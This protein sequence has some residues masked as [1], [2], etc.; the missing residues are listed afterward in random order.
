MSGML[1]AGRDD[2]AHAVGEDL[3][4][5]A[6]ERL[7][8]GCEQLLQHLLVRE[9]RELRHVV[10]LGRREAL[11]RHVGQRGLEAADEVEVVVE[12][13][14]GALAA[15][16]VDLAVRIQLVAL[17]GVLRQRPD[18]PR[19]RAVL[20]VRARERAELALHAADVR[21]VEVEVVDEVDLVAAPAQAP[22]LIGELA[23][24]EQV[25]A[26]EQRDAVV[27]VESLPRQ[28]L[29]ANGVDQRARERA[30][31]RSLSGRGLSLPAR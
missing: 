31:H 25:V 17:D 2:L 1:L 9:A 13:E 26:L 30:C 16:H 6:G 15:D 19:V 14:V 11:E 7:H 4:A 23:E 5:T 24:A 20:L 22:R 12:V 29:L 10:H 27:E 28:H 3:G 18:L 8:A 21:V